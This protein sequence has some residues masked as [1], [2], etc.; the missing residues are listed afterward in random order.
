MD[1]FLEEI[2]RCVAIH[3]FVAT[4]IIFAGNKRKEK[5]NMPDMVHFLKSQNL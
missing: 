4:I 5:R 2:K 1:T 3:I